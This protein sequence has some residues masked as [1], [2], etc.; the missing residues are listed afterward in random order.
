MTA[1]T[2]SSVCVC[3]CW[4][5]QLKRSAEVFGGGAFFGGRQKAVL[6]GSGFAS[7]YPGMQLEKTA[8]KSLG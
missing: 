6:P 8:P 5:G 4:G 2:S 1:Q 7:F 3:V